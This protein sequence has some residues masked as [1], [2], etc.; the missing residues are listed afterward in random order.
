MVKSQVAQLSSGELC[1]T[2]TTAFAYSRHEAC[3]VTL[4][5]SN[6]LDILRIYFI[7][8]SEQQI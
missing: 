1:L 8:L 2:F 5:S 6:D 7:N 3:V 4:N